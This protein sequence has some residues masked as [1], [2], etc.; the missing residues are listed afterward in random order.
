LTSQLGFYAQLIYRLDDRYS[1]SFYHSEFYN[2][3]DDTEGQAWIDM[4]YEGFYAWQKNKC[5]TSRIDITDN[6]LVKF[7]FHHI[8][9]VG[10]LFRHWNQWQDMT[11]V[12][13]DWQLF[14]VKT[15]F[16]F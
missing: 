4:G 12:E 7:E 14:A 5:L 10:Q 3:K 9:G 8:K 11:E 15:T 6:W 13:K 16:H 1:F 2:N